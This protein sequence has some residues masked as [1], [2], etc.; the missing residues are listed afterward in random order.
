[1]FLVPGIHYLSGNFHSFIKVMKGLKVITSTTRC[2]FKTS[3]PLNIIYL[4]TNSTRK[5]AFIPRN[6]SI[7]CFRICFEKIV[8]F[9]FHEKRTPLTL[10]AV[11]FFT[12]IM[13]DLEGAGTKR[14]SPHYSFGCIWEGTAGRVNFAIL[15]TLCRLYKNKNI[16]YALKI[17][18]IN[19]N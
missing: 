19:E 8:E 16:L 17:F 6:Y 7:R 1:M 9:W 5:K 11:W 10:S 12:L 18:Y 2:R 14:P 3:R 4:R 15:F 13:V